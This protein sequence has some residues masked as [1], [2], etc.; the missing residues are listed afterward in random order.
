MK[1]NTGGHARSEPVYGLDAASLATGDEA[2]HAHCAMASLARCG[3]VPGPGPGNVAVGVV[4]QLKRG[5]LCV[6]LCFEIRAPGSR[7]LWECG[8]EEGGKWVREQGFDFRGIQHRLCG[9]V[10][11][12]G[13]TNSVH[14]ERTW[15]V[16]SRMSTTTLGGSGAH[17]R[18]GGFE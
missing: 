18:G 5:G 3:G 14:E 2:V 12:I 8:G 15:R 6:R 10:G 4:A 13:T 11:D 1:G 7:T 9:E 16:L 17:E